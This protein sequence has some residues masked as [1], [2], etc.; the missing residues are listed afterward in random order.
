MDETVFDPFMGS[1]SSAVAAINSHRK[2]VGTELD[3]DTFELSKKRLNE[4]Q[5]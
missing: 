2:Y 1:G 3:E 5:R 4:I